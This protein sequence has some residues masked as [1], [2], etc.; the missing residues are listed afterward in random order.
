MKPFD[1]FRLLKLVRSLEGLSTSMRGDSPDP[2]PDDFKP[3]VIDRSKNMLKLCEE[4]GLTSA[5]DQLDRMISEVQNKSQITYREFRAFLP[6]L[7]NRIEDE[8]KRQLVMAIDTRLARDY[9]LNSQFFD[10]DDPAVNKVSVQFSTASED[11]AEAG[12]CLACSRGT[13]CV[14]HLNRVMEVGLQALASGM[15]IGKQNDWGKYL[16]AIDTELQKQ[17]KASGARSADEQFYAEAHV[18]FDSVRRAWR[19]PTMHVDK[20][21]TEERAEEIL[22]S[23]R[24]FM[25]HLATRLHD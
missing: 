9:F 24:S 6:E 20:T 14:M 7:L 22:I 23:V 16:S 1:L 15:G 11:I 10:A 8:S 3:S 4:C 2:M 12:K 17:L 19:N 13:A 21:Y 18:I 5:S 25:R